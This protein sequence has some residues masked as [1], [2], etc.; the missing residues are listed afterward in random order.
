MGGYG[1]WSLA[2]Q[3][4]SRFA[5][6]APFCG[7]GDHL[8]VGKIK[9]LPVWAFHNKNDP[10]VTCAETTEDMVTH[11]Q[12]AGGIV[13]MTLKD[14]ADHDCWSTVYSAS[15]LFDWFLEH[16]NKNVQ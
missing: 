13:K 6:I 3:F 2:T 1:A 4:P 12:R 8:Q 16:K 14:S 7:G 15:E 10:I 5:A 9:Q 11:L